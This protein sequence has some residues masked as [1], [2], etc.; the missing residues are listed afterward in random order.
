MGWCRSTLRGKR[1]FRWLTHDEGLTI[2]CGRTSDGGD[3]CMAV[4]SLGI[5][6]S[7][8][9]MISLP[10]SSWPAYI[11]GDQR[12]TEL[13]FPPNGWIRSYDEAN[14]DPLW[15][16]TVPY[17]G[18]E[19]FPALSARCR[20]AVEDLAK[21]LREE[22]PDVVVIISNDQDEWFFDDNM[23]AFSIYWGRDA[24]MRPFPLPPGRTGAVADAI[25]AG[26][27]DRTFEVSI[28]ADLGR[29]LVEQLIEA[30]FDIASN[31]QMP[32]SRGGVVVRHYLSEDGPNEVTRVTPE[33]EIGLPHG[34]SFVI[35]NLFEDSPPPVVPIFQNTCYPP[36][37]PTPNRCF[38]FGKAVADA[39]RN[40]EST[41]KV[42]IIA[43]GGLSHFIVDEELDRTVLDA[44][45]NKDDVRLRNLDQRRLYSASSE[46]LNWVALGGALH[47]SELKMEL[48]DYVAVYRTPVGTGGGWAFAKWR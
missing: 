22:P 44:L 46:A 45:A 41:A 43:S 28:E 19:V 16:A 9:P 5:G 11:E 29:H 10:V 3:W 1:S 27:G 2:G 37:R 26:Y 47:G 24:S 7:H 14:S 33:R 42:A 32:E 31:T 18:P 15:L 8:T 38:T 6:T 39:I 25:R 30:E 21:T 17:E 12:N 13:A 48:V 34:F 23:P 35:R 36:N 40:W 4:V 20:D